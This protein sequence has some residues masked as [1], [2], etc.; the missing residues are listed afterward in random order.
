M[1]EV[2]A[3]VF[4]THVPRLMIVDPEERKAYMGKRVTTFYDAMA[5]VESERLRA[6][7]FDTFVLIDSHWFTTL[8]YVLNAHQR[9]AGLY[10]SEELPH[11]LH[12][13]EYDYAGDA[14]LAR[15]IA[16]T[17][18]AH[19]MRAI[20]SA[21]RGLPLHYPTLNVMYYFNPRAN[22]RV[23]SM[24]VCQVASVDNDLAFGAA[25]GEAIRKSHR[26]VVLIGSGGM[27]H[28]FWDYDHILER[29]SASPDDISSVAN[30]LYDE[31]LMRWFRSGDHREVLAAADDYRM[32][33]SPEGLF[34]HYLIMA[35]AM[36]G[37]DWKWRGKQFGEYEA[38]IGTGQAIFYFDPRN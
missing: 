16:D 29:A 17:A 11:M 4:T 15:L 1:G 20:A 23:L 5:R 7:D 18:Q 35:G 14:E 3:A 36:G 30:R 12:K 22:R 24:G 37:A 13:L 6:L 34:S 9:I 27:S 25:M 21:H 8:D 33:C 31:K 2:V 38:A 19:R 26:R 32:H 28:K 10:T